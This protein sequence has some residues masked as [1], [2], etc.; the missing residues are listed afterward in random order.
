[1]AKTTEILTIR[2][3][4][5]RMRVSLAFCFLIGPLVRNSDAG[6]WIVNALASWVSSGLQFYDGNRRI[7]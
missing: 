6:V 5:W 4:T 7:D 3:P 1:M 2:N